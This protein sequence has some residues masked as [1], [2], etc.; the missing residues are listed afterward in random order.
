M[1]DDE[2]DFS[3]CLKELV[4]METSYEF[5][6]AQNGI[7]GLEMCLNDTYDFLIIDYRMPK[8]NGFDFLNKL[9]SRENPNQEAKKLFLSGFIE[10]VPRKSHMWGDIHFKS[11]PISPSTIIN[12]LKNIG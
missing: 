3:A 12:F 6:T 8:M 2:E 1:I 11:K 5:H 4:E 9:Y 7:E 10:E